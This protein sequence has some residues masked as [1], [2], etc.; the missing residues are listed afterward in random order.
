MY[1]AELTHSLFEAR[2]DT[3]FEPMTIADLLARKPRS[4]ATR[5]RSAKS[6][7]T[8][9]SAGR[10]PM[11]NCCATANGSA[12][13]WRRATRRGARIAMFA[14]NVP[15]WVLFEMAAALAGLTLVTVNP[16]YRR[17][18]C[19]TCSNSRAPRRSISCRR[20]RGHAL[21]PVVEEV[22][23]D[24]PAIRHR[25]LLTDHAALFAGED[26][27]RSARAAPT[28]SPRSSTRRAPPAF[29][30]ARCS[31]SWGWSRTAAIPSAAGTPRAGDRIAGHD[32]D[33]PHRRLRPAGARRARASARR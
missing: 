7:P 12:G 4:A 11:P 23:A 5:P 17:A 8:A 32:A 1:Q 29:P 14:N 33:V 20:F 15:E 28:T 25:I 24:L 2:R 10:G 27:A 16:S 18:I 26:A 6:W 9:R 22:C 3:P 30:R 21:G 31:S 13:R 19:A